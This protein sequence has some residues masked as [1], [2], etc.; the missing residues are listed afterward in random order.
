MSSS[1]DVCR[2]GWVPLALLGAWHLVACPSSKQPEV[3]AGADAG[4]HLLDDAPVLPLDTDAAADPIGAVVARLPGRPGACAQVRSLR[5]AAEAQQSAAAIRAATALPVEIVEKT[6]ADRGVWFRVCVG[7]EPDEAR[8]VARATR[9]TASDGV[10]APFLDPPRSSDEARFLVLTRAGREPRRPSD[11]QARAFLARSPRGVA[12][13]AGPLDAPLLVGTASAGDRIVVVDERGDALRLDPTA[14]PGCAACVIAEQQSPTVRRRLLATGDVMPAPGDEIVIEEETAAGTRF[15]IVVAAAG[16]PPT[17][18]R[19]GAVLLAQAS[20][21]VVS[22]GEA[23]VV[24]ADGD[25]EREIAIAHLELRSLDGNLCSLTS[26]AELWGASAETSRGLARIEVQSLLAGES[27]SV[28]DLITALDGA[29]DPEAASRAC[30]A[31]LHGR[32]GSHVGQLCLQRIRSLVAAGRPVDA[33]NAAGTIA[34]RAPALR[35][36]VAGP[37]FTAM[38]ALDADPRLTAAPWDCAAAPLVKDTVGKPVEELIGL[39]RARL[40]ER[41]SLSDV[42]DAV[43]VTASRDFGTDTPVFSIAGRWLER[44][45]VTQPARHAAIEAALLPPSSAPSNSPAADPAA[46]D[47]APGF[48]GSP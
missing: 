16:A 7:D 33:V 12:L 23:F 39:A 43:F 28:V 27:A 37:L 26:H 35:A 25:A 14:P 11:A 15:L 47:G 10:L 5:D 42:A 41:L 4:V 3:D 46:D 20:S 34:E 21:D 1:L 36:A 32:P 6:L 22:R 30:A 31:A 2:I 17:L 8:L 13:Y 44:L 19:T 40:A 45:R 29:G 48:G 24:E 18:R 38:Q 9:W